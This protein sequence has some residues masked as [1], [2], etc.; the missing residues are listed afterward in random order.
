MEHHLVYF[1]GTDFDRVKIGHCKSNLYTRKTQIQNGCPDPI[2][3]LGV[4]LCRDKRDMENCERDLHNRFY[5]HSTVG[6]WFRIVPEISDYIK[7]SAESGQDILKKG[8]EQERE[9]RR[10]QQ[11][12]PEVKERRREQRRRPEYKERRREQRQSPEYKERRRKR[13]QRP[14]VKKR[15]QEENRKYRERPEYRE[16]KREYL[17]KYRERPEVKERSQ[18]RYQNDP[19]YRESQRKYQRERRACKKREALLEHG[20]QLSLFDN[21]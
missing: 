6:E 16:Q 17:R 8:H 5:E 20:Q 7:K 13:R 21:D 14:E 19:E 10:E 3:L 1:F 18:G 2:K 12:R 4:I 11:Q 9:R 15:R